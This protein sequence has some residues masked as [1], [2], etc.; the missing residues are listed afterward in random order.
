MAC[1][2][3]LEPRCL[4]SVTA[5]GQIPVE[6]LSG[7]QTAQPIDVS[8]YFTV[9]GTI[10]DLQTNL[11]G[12]NTD[13][14]LLLTDAATPITVANFLQYVNSG[15]YANTIIHRSVPGFVIQGGGYTTDG[16][17]I[18][19]NGTIAGESSTETLKNTTGTITMALTSAGPGSATSEWFINLGDNN[20]TRSTPNLDDT[21][22]SG[23]FTVFGSVIENGMATVN[24]IAN[25]PIVDDSSVANWDTLPVQGSETNG[26]T[27]SSV[28]ASDLV[29]IN[30][31]IST[32]SLT[33]SVVSSNPSLVTATMTNGQLSLTALKAG[34]GGASVI[35]VTATDLGGNTTTQTFAVTVAN[36]IT[37]TLVAK[38]SSTVV[39]T[40]PLKLSENLTL[41][42]GPLGVVGGTTARVMLSTSAYA[43]GSV[44]TLG[45]YVGNL[46]LKAGKAKTIALTLP[47]TIPADIAAGTYH[48][49]EQ[50]IDPVGALTTIDTGQTLTIVAPVVDLSGAFT[51]LPKSITVGKKVNLTLVVTNSSTANVSAVGTLPLTIGTSVDGLSTDAVQVATGSKAINLAPGKSVKFTVTVTLSAAGNLFLVGVLDPN[52]TVFTNDTNFANNTFVSSV[53]VPVVG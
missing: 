16:T 2:Q 36:D 24:A 50:V 4:F 22:D 49:L 18:V 33:Y 25:L 28:P 30:P 42:A 27:L 13:I 26:S 23:P 31:V 43:D 45:T 21:S 46:N 5:N 37:P 44:L 12:A 47:K 9:G 41:T 19:T 20:G 7:G 15:E 1:M 48:V 17:H 8:N 34:S 29:T 11:T 6:S 38:G 51:S 53:A 39:A 52:H 40:T 14:P 3:V 35:T 10:V 32:N